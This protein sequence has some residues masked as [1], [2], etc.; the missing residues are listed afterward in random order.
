ML[1]LRTL[2]RIG[3]LVS[4]QEIDPLAQGIPSISPLLPSERPYITSSYGMRIH[5]LDQTYRMHTGLDLA[6]PRGF[7]LVY[8]TARGRVSVAGH[9]PGMGLSIALDHPGGY[10]TLYGHLSDVYVQEGEVIQVGEVIGLMGRTGTATGV[11]LH[12]SLRKGGK[13]VDPLPYLTLYEAFLNK[14]DAVRASWEK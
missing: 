11:H 6:C 2:L 8:A 5:P 14:K 13:W 1:F 7:Q 4:A 10:G 12:Y 9:R 3:W